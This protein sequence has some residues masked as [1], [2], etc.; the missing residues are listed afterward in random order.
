VADPGRRRL[1]KPHSSKT[2]RAAICGKVAPR[3][4][5]RMVGNPEAGHGERRFRNVADG[6]RKSRSVVL[7]QRDMESL[8]SSLASIQ[9]FS[10]AQFGTRPPNVVAAGGPGMLLKM[11]VVSRRKSGWVVPP[12]TQG[13]RAQRDSDHGWLTQAENNLSWR[14]SRTQWS[15]RSTARS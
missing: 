12:F 7:I 6:P 11:Q 13:V 9:P 3:N 1:I 15:D 2:F 4:S 8:R 14:A 10:A 5:G